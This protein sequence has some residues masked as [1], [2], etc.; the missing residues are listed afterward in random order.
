MHHSP[1][2]TENKAMQYQNVSTYIQL[3]FVIGKNYS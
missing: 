3:S 1:L 2:Y